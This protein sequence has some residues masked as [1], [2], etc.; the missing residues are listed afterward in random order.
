MTPLAIDIND[1][2]SLH[3]AQ[4][5]RDALRENGIPEEEV[6][7]IMIN[8]KRGRPETGMSDGDTVSLFPLI[9]GG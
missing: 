1:T 7:I 2:R 8:G 9:G 3:A 5:V 6:A 4:L